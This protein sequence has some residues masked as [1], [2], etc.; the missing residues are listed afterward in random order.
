MLDIQIKKSLPGFN[1]EV[2]FNVDRE[3]LAI[4]GPSG[5]GKTMTLKCVAGL[6]EAD[7]G[8]I[9][10]DDKVFFDSHSRVNLKSQER[11]V[12]FVFQNYALFPHM[13][14]FKNIAFGIRSLTQEEIKEKV[15]LWMQKMRLNGLEKRFPGQLSAGQQQRV[16]LARALVSEPDVL[17]LDEPF[18]ALDSIVK[19]RLEEELLQLHEFFPGQ[20]LFVTHNLAEA[21]KLSS[22]IAVFE[23]GC[24]VQYGA[25]ETVINNPSNRTAARLTGVKNI[26]P[27]VIQKV[28]EARVHMELGDSKIQLKVGKEA[29]REWEIGQAVNL[30]IRS[31]YIQVK[32][33]S[34]ENT[35]MVMVEEIMEE[36]SSYTVRCSLPYTA[37]KQLLEARIPRSSAINLIKGDSCQI[38]LPADKLFIMAD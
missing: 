28:E 2:S 22:K 10:L 20:V 23:A 8:R 32:Q 15:N 11:N 36:I 12:G 37:E 34:S 19:E 38:Y 16:A 3:I 9:S 6:M 31:E 5:C 4:L 24:L 26:L 30:G 25:K 18:S 17:L 7:E 14:V 35:F 21:Y 29:G 13:N 33:P 1:L 27:A